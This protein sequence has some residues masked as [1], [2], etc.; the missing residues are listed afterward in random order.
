M[1]D[2]H[3]MVYERVIFQ[4][5]ITAIDAGN[6]TQLDWFR[7][8][9]DTFRTITMNVYAYR[10]G[11][12]FGFT[13]ISFDKYGWFSRPLFLDA[14]ELAFGDTSRYGNYSSIKLGKGLND[15]WT[16]AISYS[17]GVAGGGYSLSVY[18]K[19]FK[20]RMD[21]LTVA[22]NDLKSKMVAKIGSTDTLNDKQPIILATLRD[23]EKAQIKMVQLSLF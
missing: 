10:K 17:Y 3:M 13:Q 15:I 9:G 6:Q 11:L 12:E 14:E 5:M 8:F 19:K 4:E 1:K 23:I 21:A 7:T 2:N 16:Y 20:N 18:G 22:L